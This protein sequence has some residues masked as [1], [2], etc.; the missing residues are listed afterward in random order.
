[1]GG[2][3]EIAYFAQLP[4]LYATYGLPMPLV[5]P[6]AR[7]RVVDDRAR[8]LLEKTGLAPD[9]LAAPREALLARLARPD[10][11]D[12][13]AAVEA[14]F[15]AAISPEFARLSGQMAAI[16]PNLAKT[17]SRTEESVRDALA[18]LVAKY[19]RALSQ[20]DQVAV[21]RLDRLRGY[22]APDGQPQ[23]RVH[24]LP[25]YASRWGTRGFARLVLD[26]CVPFD[27]TLRDLTP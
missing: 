26:A 22:L 1:V 5:V 6:R 20:R 3:G 8:A 18:K 14:R 11:F 15:A 2:P 7:F 27:G 16:D 19:G 12:D 13:P 23:E 25:Y 17:V 24:G 4:P 21:E 10:G 9:D